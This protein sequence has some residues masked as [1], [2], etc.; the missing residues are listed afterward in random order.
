MS[1]EA[2]GE[3]GVGG[4]R[5]ITL[6]EIVADNGS[7]VVGEVPGTLPFVSRRFFALYGIPA[8][9]A[10]GTHAHRECEQFLVCLRGSVRA[11]VDDGRTQ[12]TVLLDRPD[13]GLYMP[14]LTWGTQSDYS[15]DALLLVFASHE[16][17]AADYIEDYEEFLGLVGV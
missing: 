13:L 2:G 9:E 8:G 17:D 6:R 1:T 10:R 7:L 12:R 5:L 14:K 4:S 16:Y 3:L 15:H 11:L